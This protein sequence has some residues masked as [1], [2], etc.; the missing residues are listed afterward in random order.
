MGSY[1]PTHRGANLRSYKS[2][3]RYTIFVAI[4]RAYMGPNKP[5]NGDTV[6]TAIIGAYLGSYEP[7][8]RSANKCPIQCPIVDTNI[9]SN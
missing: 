6:F 5:T 9:S 3:D 4:F 7:T 8:H 1:E 2:A